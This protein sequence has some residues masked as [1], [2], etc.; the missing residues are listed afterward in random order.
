MLRRALGSEYGDPLHVTLSRNN[1]LAFVADVTNKTVYVVDYPSGDV[2]TTLSGDR[3]G[4]S[5][6]AGAVDG[7]NAVY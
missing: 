4:L 3:D 6:P 5:E 2:V 7:P 1:T